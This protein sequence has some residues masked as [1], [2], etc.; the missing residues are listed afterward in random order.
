MIVHA[1]VKTIEGG[2]ICITARFEMQKPI[3]YMP[4]TLWYSFPE[5]YAKQTH[6]R[7][8]AFA[9]TAL[10]I[11]MYS[12]EDLRVQGAIS[13][14]LAYSLY[15]YQEIFLAWYPNLFQRIEIQYEQ[16]VLPPSFESANAVVT[17]FSGGVDSFYTLWANLPK[18]QPIPHAQ[19]THGLFVRGID[20]RLDDKANYLSTVEPYGQMFKDLG[21]ELIQ[22]AT[23]ANQFAEFRI[24]W[25]IF[26][27]APLIGCAMLLAPWLTRFYVPSS[28]LS[29]LKLIPQGSHPL[30]DHL[31]S[32]ETIEIVHHGAAINR[33]DK[34]DK[35]VHWPVTH[36][37]LRVC[38]DKL[39]LA[40]LSNCSA[41]HKCYR[42]MTLLELLDALPN[43]KNF[44]KK[45]SPVDYLRWGILMPPSKKSR[46]FVRNQAFRNGHISMAL[47]VQ[48]TLILQHLKTYAIKAIKYILS[49]EQ[50]YQ[51]KRKIFHPEALDINFRE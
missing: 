10:L 24:D 39:R 46:I 44:S 15:E 40:G 33:Y 19:V 47:W 13:P 22:A 7:S 11:A 29:Y 32:T 26:F 34:L 3:P 9:P 49:Q 16:L 12:G 23:N 21:L 35:L 1:P 5:H 28:M 41:C 36:N 45:M 27:G 18:N 8:D 48:V 50:L 51:L 31:L 42:T 6:S 4:P 37:K 30:I 17:A 2:Q 25:P 38:A 20:L 14:K 43:Y